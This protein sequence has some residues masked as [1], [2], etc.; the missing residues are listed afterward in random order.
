[1]D[2]LKDL[3]AAKRESETGL[4]EVEIARRITFIFASAAYGKLRPAALSKAGAM[5]FILYGTPDIDPEKWGPRSRQPTVT[6]GH[7]CNKL[8]SIVDADAVRWGY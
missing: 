4:S 8:A 5:H 7:E 1:M 3:V 6:I 2:G